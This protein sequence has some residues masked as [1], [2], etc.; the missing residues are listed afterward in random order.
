M[1]TAALTKFFPGA[2][3]R[4]IPFP[5]SGVPEEVLPY[6]RRVSWSHRA[7]RYVPDESGDLLELTDEGV[8]LV[9]EATQRLPTPFELMQEAARR[10]GL[11]VEFYGYGYNS[12]A[13]IIVDPRTGVR[14]EHRFGD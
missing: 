13:I 2:D 3:H 10:R 1:V 14:V 9:R 8:A 12:L 5:A 11:A 6:V 4:R 7:G